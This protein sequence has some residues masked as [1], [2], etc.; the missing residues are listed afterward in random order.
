MATDQEVMNAIL[1]KLYMILNAG[2]TVNPAN[3]TA[4]SN[5]SFVLYATPGIPLTAE[6]LKFGFNTTADEIG[7]GAAF[8]DLVNSIPQPTGF[9]RTS[10]ARVWD[11]YKRA[12]DGA[13]LAEAP[14][15][16]EEVARLKRAHD[17][18]YTTS[19][20]IDINT[21]QPKS[22]PVDT[23]LY[24]RYVDLKAAYEAELLQYNSLLINV[25]TNPNDPMALAQLNING[26]I[27]RTR[28]QSAFN[29]WA[30]AGK[31]I[32]ETA[33]ATI[34]QLTGRDPVRIFS[35]ARD[36]LAG[37]ERTDTDGQSYYFTKY[38]PTRF[39][40][41][42]ASWTR[43]SMSEAE[44]HTTDTSTASAWGGGAGISFG[45][46]SFGASASH[47]SAERRQT[48]NTSNFAL[49][50]QLTRLPIRRSW[51]TAGIL[52]SKSWKFPQNDPTPLS[53]GGNPP[54][55]AMIGYPTELILA[56]DLRITM[57][58]SS[59]ADFQA[60]SQ[61]S[62]GGKVGWGPFSVRGNYHRETSTQTHDFTRNGNEISSPGMQVI[63]FICQML[64]K[65]P[66]PD[67]A[68]DFPD[69]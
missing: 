10:T 16:D 7:V 48:A 42:S 52:T 44:V 45:L 19:T 27:L 9:W 37:L 20:I 3:R 21:G 6:D 17:T 25:R 59:M 33:T 66:D 4:P 51:F 43:F 58:S 26:P 50:V 23:T 8:A 56:K 11:E 57:D 24:E 31:N 64:P 63:G 53:D 1:G 34:D 13:V 15:S 14:L 38:F 65:A 54:A 61:L 2:D 35:A 47:S 39:D 40:P 62:V 12:L 18:L 55:G 68:I 60:Q 49:S 5:G 41:N 67:P 30:S 29:R 22:V 46:W 36:R 69:R 28:V 32:V